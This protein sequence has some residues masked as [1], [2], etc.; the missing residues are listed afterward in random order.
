VGSNPT[1]PTDV[2]SQDIE[3]SLGPHEVRVL[4]FS[5]RRAYWRAAGELV[6]AGSG[7]YPQ[8]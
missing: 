5:A 8:I 2:R 1:G 7:N 6:V 3:D 4:V